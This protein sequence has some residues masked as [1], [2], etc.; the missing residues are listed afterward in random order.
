MKINRSILKEPMTVGFSGGIDSVCLLYWLISNG[1]DVSAIHVNHN[2]NENSNKWADFCQDFCYEYDISYLEFNVHVPK[3]G[4]LEQEARRIRY[5]CFK[6]VEEN[7]VLAHHADDQQ[8]TV[9]LKLIRG[10]GIHGLTG[11]KEEINIDSIPIIR[12]MLNTTRKEIMKYATDHN[13]L[14]NEDP[15]NLDNKNDRNFLR[16]VVLPVI[17]DRFSHFYSSLNRSLDSLREDHE[18]L[19]EIAMNDEQTIEY[20]TGWDIRKVNDLSDARIKNV[21]KH[22]LRNIGYYNYSHSILNEFVKIIRGNNPNAKSKFP[23]GHQR[24]YVFLFHY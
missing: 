5:D 9:F 8:E 3:T 15:S 16:N 10:S 1:Y 2:I 17:N 19:E 7:I 4:N 23:F 12:P 14:W 22:K 20:K 13:L 21:L 6:K 24:G 18:I 11:M